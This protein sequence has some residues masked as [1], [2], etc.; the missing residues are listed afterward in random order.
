M[1]LKI[2]TQVSEL[3]LLLSY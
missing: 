1:R 3:M 2:Y